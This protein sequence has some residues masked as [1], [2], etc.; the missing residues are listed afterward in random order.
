MTHVVIVFRVA[1]HLAKLASP[2]YSVHSLVRDEGHFEDIKSRGANPVLLSLEDASVDQLADTFTGSQAVVF[3]A[4]AGGK[5]GA[6]RT[7]LVDE[8]GAIKV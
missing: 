7:K 3:A 1:L 5:G 2:A 6:E 4:G 8:Q